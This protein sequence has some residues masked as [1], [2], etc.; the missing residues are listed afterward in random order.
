MKKVLSGLLLVI[1][2]LLMGALGMDEQPSFKPYEAP[3]LT[4]PPAAVPISGKELPVSWDTPLENPVKATEESVARGKV[5]FEIN[6]RMCHGSQPGEPGPVGK[7]LS[8]PPPDLHQKQAQQLSDADIFKRITLGFGRMPVFGNRLS[9]AERWDLVN[10][11][12]SLK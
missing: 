12:H 10:Y 8:P 6:C 2:P 1:A 11:V 9:P 5:L 3:V 7:K 4:P